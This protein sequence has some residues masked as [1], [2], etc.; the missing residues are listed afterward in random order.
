MQDD[1]DSL[2]FTF[3]KAF[4]SVSLHKCERICPVMKKDLHLM[5]VTPLHTLES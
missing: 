4:D 2:T 5:S 1:K 3:K